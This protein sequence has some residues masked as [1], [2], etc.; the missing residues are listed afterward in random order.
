MDRTVRLARKKKRL[1]V[2]I[3]Q[4]RTLNFELEPNKDVDI[5]VS[6][7]DIMNDSAIADVSTEMLQF[8]AFGSTFPA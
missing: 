3:I 4:S 5:C 8:P 7:S 1:C 2:E 6:K